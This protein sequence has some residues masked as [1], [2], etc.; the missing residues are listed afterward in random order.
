ML[1]QQRKWILNFNRDFFSGVSSY[2]PIISKE[3]CV[4]YNKQAAY[5]YLMM[6]FHE[7]FQPSFSRADHCPRLSSFL[8]LSSKTSPQPF[9]T[10]ALPS[11]SPSSG[12]CQNQSSSST[13]TRCG[14]SFSALASFNREK[15]NHDDWN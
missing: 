8:P 13:G 10:L 7:A 12:I 3:S 11:L 14:E 5:E 1:P 2:A 4:K 9:S 15:I 6:A